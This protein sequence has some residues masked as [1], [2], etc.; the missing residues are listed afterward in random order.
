MEG[1]EVTCN[2]VMK[3]LPILK[4]EMQLLSDAEIYKEDLGKIIYI[5]ISAIVQESI[6]I[7]LLADL[8]DK[9]QRKELF[10]FI[11]KNMNEDLI[12]YA[13]FKYKGK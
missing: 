12:Q 1:Y 9:T 5:V 11:L 4:Q 6:E 7:F 13:E 8:T 3:I 10:N 2:I